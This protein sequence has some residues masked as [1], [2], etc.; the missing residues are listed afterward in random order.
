V[1]EFARQYCRRLLALPPAAMNA[2]RDGFHEDVH[3]AL[4]AR[5]EIIDELLNDWFSEES[6]ENLRARA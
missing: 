1:V 2:M 6:Q 4:D 3:R 5:D